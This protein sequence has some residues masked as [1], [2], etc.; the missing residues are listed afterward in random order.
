MLGNN[1]V[2]HQNVKCG[3]V[4]SVDGTPVDEVPIGLYTK[5]IKSRTF[6]MD[7]IQKLHIG[8]LSN[9]V[10]IILTFGCLYQYY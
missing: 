9:L 10:Q 4:E 3:T 1:K 8:K 7:V 6:E 2:M 5:F